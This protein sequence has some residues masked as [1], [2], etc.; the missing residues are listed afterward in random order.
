MGEDLPVAGVDLP[1]SAFPF[2]VEI[3]SGVT[4]ERLLH[5]VVAG[6][7]ALSIPGFAD[8]APNRVVVTWPDGTTSELQ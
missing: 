6:P 2:T 4:G 5:E 7:G 1:A 3:F 8:H